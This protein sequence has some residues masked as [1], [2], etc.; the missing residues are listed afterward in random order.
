[1]RIGVGYVQDGLN[2]DAFINCRNICTLKDASIMNAESD[3]LSPE[4]REHLRTLLSYHSSPF[5]D[6]PSTSDSP[7]VCIC[8]SYADLR[9]IIEAEY[10]AKLDSRPTVPATYRAGG[11]RRKLPDSPLGGRASSQYRSIATQTRA[12]ETVRSI[13]SAPESRIYRVAKHRNT[14]VPRATGWSSSDTEHVSAT[15]RPRPALSQG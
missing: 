5:L 7:G 12:A 11:G 9:R 6:F 1:M 13:E 4:S 3:S 15:R 10:Q 8:T 2:L 14:R